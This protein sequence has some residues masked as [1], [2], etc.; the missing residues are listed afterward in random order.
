MLR[1]TDDPEQ[2]GVVIADVDPLSPAREAGIQPGDVLLSVAGQATNARFPESLPLVRRVLADLVVGQESSVVVSRGGEQHTLRVVPIEKRVQRG[3]ETELTAWGFTAS[4]VTP[5]IARQAQLTSNDGVFVSG[6]Q[7][8]SL[9][10]NAGLRHGDVVL[11]MDD[12]PVRDLASFEAGYRDRLASH[13][14][15]ILVE[16]KRGALTRYVLIKQSSETDADNL[17]E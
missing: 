11:A 2:R 8:G 6:V 9:A 1:K 7:A 13:Q 4:D 12:E 3:K 10:A 17:G 16:V 15:L 14:R 5:E